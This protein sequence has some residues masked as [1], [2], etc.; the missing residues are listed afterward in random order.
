MKE[1]KSQRVR[2]SE[3]QNKSSLPLRER[4]GVRGIIILLL[5]TF[6]FS[7]FT[8]VTGCGKKAPPKPPQEAVSV[9]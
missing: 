4:V 2:V 1:S 3:C 5:F 6:H 9:K 7:L 8:V